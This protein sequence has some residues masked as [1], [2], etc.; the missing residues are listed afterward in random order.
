MPSNKQ[1]LYREARRCSD[2]ASK[3]VTPGHRR[4]FTGLAKFYETL[5]LTEPQPDVTPGSPPSG[6]DVSGGKIDERR[7]P[8]NRG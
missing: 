6:L 5:A 2:A 8:R 1:E 7:D 4:L 3:G